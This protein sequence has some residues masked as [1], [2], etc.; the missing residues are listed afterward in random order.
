VKIGEIR[1]RADSG[2]EVDLTAATAETLTTV[3]TDMDLAVLT[4]KLRIISARVAA[5]GAAEPFS[6]TPDGDPFR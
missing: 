5:A 6:I 4:A 1:Y 3:L 2:A